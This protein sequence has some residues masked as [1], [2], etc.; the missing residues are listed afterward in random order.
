M[1]YV[2]QV[3]A[4]LRH[5]HSNGVIHRDIKPQNLLLTEDRETAKIADFGVARL[6]Q[7]DTP[8]TRVGTN[9][10]APPEHS[11]FSAATNGDLKTTKLT[12]ASDI[13]SL[14]KSIYTLL[15]SESPRYL[16]TNQ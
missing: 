3:C 4:G 15:T 14:A 13:Y 5:A 7:A 8:I 12:P 16:R 1:N 2:E 9:A 6:S 11:P 10:Y